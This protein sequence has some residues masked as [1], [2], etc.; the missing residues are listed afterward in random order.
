MSY[1]AC[2]EAELRTLEVGGRWLRY[3]LIAV[4][5]QAAARVDHGLVRADMHAERR[6]QLCDGVGGRYKREHGRD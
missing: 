2:V 1:Y 5:M 6:P 3:S 4:Q